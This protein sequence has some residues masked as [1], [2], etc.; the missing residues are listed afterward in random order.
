MRFCAPALLLILAF[1]PRPA[2]AWSNKEHLQLTRIAALRLVNAPDTPPEMKRWLRDVMPDITDMEVE[3]AFFLNARVGIYP[4]GA[5]GLGF[6]ATVPDLD[7]K[8]VV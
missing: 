7:R 4:I 6:W 1:L 3:K 2:A 8:S 5:R